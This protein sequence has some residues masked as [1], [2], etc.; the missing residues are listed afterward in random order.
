[1][2]QRFDRFDSLLIELTHAIDLRSQIS[3]FIFILD[4]I[5]NSNLT[6]EGIIAKREIRGSRERANRYSDQ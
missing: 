5:L 6:V 4:L 3:N 1:V 2:R